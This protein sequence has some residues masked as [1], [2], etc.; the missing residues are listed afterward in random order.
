[1]ATSFERLL[2]Q[3]I[4]SRGAYWYWLQDNFQSLGDAYDE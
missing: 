2:E 1:V 4:E 3:L